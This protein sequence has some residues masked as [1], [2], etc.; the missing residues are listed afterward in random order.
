MCDNMNT[1]VGSI[2]LALLASIHS[3]PNVEILNPETKLASTF[4]T[5][6]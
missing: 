2:A 4:A 3:V 6:R 5:A 1:V